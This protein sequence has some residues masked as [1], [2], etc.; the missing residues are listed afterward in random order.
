MGGGGGERERMLKKAA[1]N[2]EMEIKMSW[3]VDGGITPFAVGIPEG[4]QGSTEPK[5][6]WKASARV[7]VE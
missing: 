3:A 1:W 2:I 4:R 6:K 7:L 5:W